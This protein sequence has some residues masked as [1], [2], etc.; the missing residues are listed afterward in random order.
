MIDACC[1]AGS[2]PNELY[3]EFYTNLPEIIWEGADG[4]LVEPEAIAKFGVQV[5]G[6]SEWAQNN[7]Q[8]VEIDPKWR[9]NV[10]LYNAVCIDGN[11]CVLPQDDNMSECLSIVG[12]GDTIDEALKMVEDASDGV[13]AYGLKLPKGSSDE[14][15]AEAEKLSEIGLPVFHLE[16]SPAAT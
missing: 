2:P 15:I 1:R 10:K 13:R 11:Y 14:A 4:N 7:P 8:P 12:W 5:I 9:R 3:Q 6:K 16:K